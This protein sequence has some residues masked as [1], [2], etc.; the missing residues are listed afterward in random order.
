M[1]GFRTPIVDDTETHDA[2]TGPPAF[3]TPPDD[4]DP[5]SLEERMTPGPRPKITST[6]YQS[7][8]TKDG[9]GMPWDNW[10]PPNFTGVATRIGQA[11][12]EAESNVQTQFTSG[13]R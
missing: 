12:N 4:S 6:A 3:R 7:V 9:G 2:H 1:S 11:M 8:P 13:Q 5:G 10:T